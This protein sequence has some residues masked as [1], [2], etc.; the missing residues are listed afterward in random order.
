MESKTIDTFLIKG[1]RYTVFITAYIFIGVTLTAILALLTHIEAIIWIGMALFIVA[2]GL[3]A[4][5]FRK[6]FTQQVKLLFADELLYIE[7]VEK[8]ETINIYYGEIQSVRV[9]DSTKDDSLFLRVFFKDKTSLKFTFVKQ[10]SKYLKV[11]VSEV[12][13]QFLNSYNKTQVNDAK[14]TIAPSLFARK[15]GKIYIYVIS[16]LLLICIMLQILLNPKTIPFSLLGA[17]AFYLVIVVQKKR[18]IEISKKLS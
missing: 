3:F 13:F 17:I 7:K 1:E 15:E 5:F 2:P 12:L 6:S 11:P 18:D 8:Y 10:S 9:I 16:I 4:N 14:I